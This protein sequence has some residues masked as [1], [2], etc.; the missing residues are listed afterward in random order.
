MFISV[1]DCTAVVNSVKFP[2]AVYMFTNRFVTISGH[3]VIVTS[4]LLT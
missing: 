1:P 4:D 2:Q 3:F